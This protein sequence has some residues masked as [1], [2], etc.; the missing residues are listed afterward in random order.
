MHHDSNSMLIVKYKPLRAILSFSQTVWKKANLKLDAGLLSRPCR[1][2]RPS[3]RDVGGVSWFFWSCPDATQEPSLLSSVSSLSQTEAPF[4][5]G[6][7]AGRHFCF[8][9]LPQ[10][11]ILCLPWAKPGAELWGS[12]LKRTLGAW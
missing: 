6:S 4:H 12:I 5:L 2:R 10:T 8:S 11:C 7:R 1:K 9:H 3:S